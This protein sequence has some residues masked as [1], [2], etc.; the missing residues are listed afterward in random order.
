MRNI[1][2]AGRDAW[3]TWIRSGQ[4]LRTHARQSTLRVSSITDH[5]VE[6][7]A[8]NNRKVRLDYDHLDA[9]WK[10]RERV[11]AETTKPQGKGK[12]SLNT[13]SDRVWQEAGLSRDSTNESYYWAVVCERREGE[14]GLLGLDSDY[15]AAEGEPVLRRHLQYERNRVLVKRKKQAVLKLTGRLACEAC[16]FDY[17][18]RY[19][20]LGRDFCE[21]HHGKPL[22]KREERITN[23]DDLYILCS[24]CHRMIHRTDPM[25]SVEI[26]RRRLGVVLRVKGH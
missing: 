23:L 7:L 8:K 18:E 9:L 5:H 19:L 2:T 16:G 25:E 11:D 13:M 3:K 22:A 21:V 26:F 15:D 14:A 17:A 12:V 24:N 1:R 10:Q 20:D 4:V 6:I